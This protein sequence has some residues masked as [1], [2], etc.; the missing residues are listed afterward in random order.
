MLAKLAPL[1]I[2]AV[3]IYSALTVA[4]YVVA[5]LQTAFTFSF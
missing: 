1:A 4:S 5:Y 3:A 2:L